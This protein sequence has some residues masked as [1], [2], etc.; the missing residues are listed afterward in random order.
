MAYLDELEGQMEPYT[1]DQRCQHLL[2]S[3]RPELRRKIIE[4]PT[5]PQ[6]RAKLL[7]LAIRIED[8]QQESFARSDKEESSSGAGG[9][10]PQSGSLPYRSNRFQKKSGDKDES[11]GQTTK[12]QVETSAQ[13]DS[14]S[15]EGRSDHKEKSKKK[16]REP[17]CYGCKQVGHI[18]PNCPNKDPKAEAQ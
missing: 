5:T 1:E 16:S 4:Q 12:V 9:K 17:K 14:G 10:A 8:A 6:K 13:T 15:A 11:K 7:T 3:L 2:N 18:R